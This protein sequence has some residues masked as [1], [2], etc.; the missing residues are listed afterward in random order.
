MLIPP[1]HKSFLSFIYLDYC[2]NNPVLQVFTHL[3]TTSVSKDKVEVN[4]EL[5]GADD[6]ERANAAKGKMS[7]NCVGKELAIVN[8]EV[9]SFRGGE[10]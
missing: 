7:K 3:L 10:T 2:Y 9:C 6:L 5:V 8:G 1:G 4:V